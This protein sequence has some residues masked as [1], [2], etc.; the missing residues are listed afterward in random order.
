MAIT[1]RIYQENKYIY[2]VKYFTMQ[3]NDYLLNTY[4]R[5]DAI[6]RINQLAQD[7]KPFLFIID[8]SQQNTYIDVFESVNKDNIKFNFRG[9]GND[10]QPPKE[11]LYKEEHGKIEWNV[12]VPLYND[13][14]QKFK[15]VKDNIMKGNSYLTNLTDC[16]PITTNL[17]MEEI[18]NRSVAQYK[19]HIKDHFVCFSPESFV[20][21]S[22]QRICTFPMKGTIDASIHNAERLLMDDKKEAAEHATIVDL[23]RNDLSIVADH[24]IVDKYRYIE[25]LKTNKGSIL[26]T[27]SEISGI[28]PDNY[29]T[30]L[31]NILF[32]LLPAGSITGAPKEKTI[33]IISEAEKYERGFYSGIM[34]Y[35]DNGILDSAVMIRF[36]E[37]NDKDLFFKAGGGITSKSDC[38]KEYNELIQ[39]IY[40]PIY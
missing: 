10:C 40:V 6:Q 35:Y 27:S 12:Q 18:Y 11:E 21:I 13:Y 20:R 39:K 26:Q 17:S 38:K 19:L 2:E 7:C 28:L 33:Q 5:K 14:K 25:E 16:V 37:K 23:L 29:R 31:G 30:H 8:Y 9:V 3:I 36:I 32:S 34:G 22:N 24:V 1:S 15:I 4:N